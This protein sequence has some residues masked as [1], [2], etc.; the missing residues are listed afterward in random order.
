M[1]PRTDELGARIISPLDKL[2][3]SIKKLSLNI[4]DKEIY[5]KKAFKL[6]IPIIGLKYLRN[7][8]FGLE[9]NMEKFAAI[10]FKKGCFIG[11]ENTARMKLKNKIRKKLMPLKIDNT[12][13]TG[14]EIKFKEIVVGK[15]LIP[16]PYPFGLIKIFDPDLS[17]FKGM[18]LLVDNKIMR[19]I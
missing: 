5:Y 13:K 15:V 7:N 8:L 17:V 3:L 16:N 2:Y 19:I 9:A 1:D 4:T 14:S 6:G 12:I 10:D 11:Q 18:D